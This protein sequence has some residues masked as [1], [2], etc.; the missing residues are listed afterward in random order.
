MYICNFLKN[1]DYQYRRV[2]DAFIKKSVSNC[3]QEVFI[4]SLLPKRDGTNCSVWQIALLRNYRNGNSL[5]MCSSFRV[6][7]KRNNFYPYSNQEG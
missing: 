2:N 6:M 3:G 4:I 5:K 7:F 1:G